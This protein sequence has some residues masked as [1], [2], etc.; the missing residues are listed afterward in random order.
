MALALLSAA[1]LAERAA[2]HDRRTRARHA[3]DRA[4]QC[5]LECLGNAR[6]P[7]ASLRRQCSE[8]ARSAAEWS[9]E[10]PEHNGQQ[11]ELHAALDELAR[12][13]EGQDEQRLASA[14]ARSARAGNALGW[15]TTGTSL[16]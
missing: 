8:T 14:V 3:F 15:R 4:R 13:L 11:L 16:R 10:L 7:H 2:L 9:W 1:I 12:A 6:S 5:A